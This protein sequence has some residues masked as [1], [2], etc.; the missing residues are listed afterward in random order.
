VARAILG[1][2]EPHDE[3]PFFWSDQLGL[4][5]QYVGHGQGWAR[6]EID[7]DSDSFSVRYLGDDGRLVAA[8]LANR[9]AE[10]A[11]VRREL[12]A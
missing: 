7:G 6:V 9:P 3:P 8:L 10:A 2:E 11:T 5:L 1:R 4:R 12:A